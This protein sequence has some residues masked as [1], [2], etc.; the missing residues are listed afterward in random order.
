MIFQCMPGF[1]SRSRGHRVSRMLAA[2]VLSLLGGA[3]LAA[4]PR[5]RDGGNI[6]IADQFNNRVIEVTRQNQI[7]FSQGMVG[8][9]GAGA[10]GLNAPYD[11][12]SIGDF[13]GLTP[14]FEGEGMPD[15]DD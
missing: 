4:N 10:A 1:S 2:S 12:K 8:V 14:P 7:V 15:G 13:T 6:L 3:L 5:P 11:A 9:A